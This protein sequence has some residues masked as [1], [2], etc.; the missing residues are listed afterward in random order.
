MNKSKL[1]LHKI[2]KIN[3][4]VIICRNERYNHEMITI[5][6]K[7]LDEGRFELQF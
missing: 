7:D 3:R 5:T 4:K 2:E 6:R 1:N